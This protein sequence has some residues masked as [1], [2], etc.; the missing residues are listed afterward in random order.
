MEI[1]ITELISEIVSAISNDGLANIQDD[2][3][4]VIETVKGMVFVVG[5]IIGTLQ[6]FFGYKLF[7]VWLSIV[8]FFI[9]G[10]AGFVIGGIALKDLDLGAIIGFISALIFAFITVRVYYI[11]LFLFGGAISFLISYIMTSQEIVISLIFATIIGL[12]TIF[13]GKVYIIVTT[14]LIGGATLSVTTINLFS[15]LG[16]KIDVGY[17]VPITFLFIFIY[18]VIGII[19]QNKTNISTSNSKKKP[20]NVNSNKINSLNTNITTD[21]HTNINIISRNIDIRKSVEINNTNIDMPVVY[22][23][24]NAT[25][26]EKNTVST[27]Q[28]QIPLVNYLKTISP[29]IR[30]IIVASFAFLLTVLSLLLITQKNSVDRDMP[31]K[32]KE[33]VG[34]DQH[35]GSVIEY[36]NKT[37][38]TY[39]GELYLIEDNKYKKIVTEL[40]VSNFTIYNDKIYFTKEFPSDESNSDTNWWLCRS[41]LYGSNISKILNYSQ[42]DLVLEYKILNEYIYYQTSM[43]SMLK[44]IRIDGQCEDI[45]FDRSKLEDFTAV[46]IGNNPSL[47]IDFIIEN[48]QIFIVVDYEYSDTYYKTKDILSI[49]PTNLSITSLFNGD[50]EASVGEHDKLKI[51]GFNDSEVLFYVEKYQNN[52]NSEYPVNDVNYYSTNKDGSGYKNLL[53]AA[54][55]FVNN[56]FYVDDKLWIVAKESDFNY[57]CYSIKEQSFV[58][59][60]N[61]EKEY[62]FAIKKAVGFKTDD[63]YYWLENTDDKHMMSLWRAKNDNEVAELVLDK[64]P[65]DYNFLFENTQNDLY[66]IAHNRA[67]LEVNSNGYGNFCTVNIKKKAIEYI[68]FEEDGTV[69]ILDSPDN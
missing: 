24:E 52:D 19:Y 53:S 45:V 62:M 66:G 65:S 23:E 12:I 69:N 10:I 38:L 28:K 5:L 61:P 59:L 25:V 4:T 58:E 30:I 55:P 16:I 21:E 46:N 54:I 1:G 68:I 43:P 51:L 67:Y 31:P 39:E 26:S 27:K 17:T 2:I 6:C 44:R 18:T 47:I 3:N 9:G 60:S 48:D 34:G 32:F 36:K 22:T 35:T 40:A 14:S 50:E 42:P 29:K 41:D 20:A 13:I 64:I 37:Y 11:G 57:K 56:S 49:D 7:K 15:I 8:G 33:S 63:M